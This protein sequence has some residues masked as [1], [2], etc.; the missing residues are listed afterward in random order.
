MLHS[1]LVTLSVG[2]AL[3]L[4][5]LPLTSLAARPEWQAAARTWPHAVDVKRA[6][7]PSQK[8]PL[9]Y[10]LRVCQSETL[11]I[12]GAC[13][14]PSV[15]SNENRAAIVFVQFFDD[16]RNKLTVP[17]LP[18]SR[19]FKCPYFHVPVGR[20]PARFSKELTAPANASH[21]EIR[22]S[23]FY[24]DKP[25]LLTDFKCTVRDPGKWT[26]R[27]QIVSVWFLLFVTAA[28]LAYF[29]LPRIQPYVLLAASCAFYAFF[30][31]MPFLFI[32]ASAASIWAGGLAI[33]RA[34]RGREWL[35]GAVVAFN[36]GILVLLKYIHP[37]TSVLVPLGI[38]FYSLQAISYAWDVK[39][40]AIPAERNP[41]KLALYLIF[42]PTVMQG[43][44]SRYGQIGAQLWS[45]HRYSWDRMQSGMELALWGFFKK[46]VIADRAAMLADAV[47]APGATM[48]GFP[49]LL[50]VICYSVQIYADF[51]GCVDICRGI[52]EVAGIEL[53]ENF[54]HPYFSTSVKD[55][56]HRWHISLSTWLRDYVYIP[57]GGNRKG[58]FRKHLN[59]LAT[60]G[61]SGVWHGVG[62]N[63]FAWGLLH[64]VYQVLDALTI[65]LRKRIVATLGIDDGSFSFRLGQRVWTFLLVSFAWI[66]FRA[67]TIADAWSVIR[68]MCVFNPWTWT[69][70]SCLKHGLDAMDFDVLVASLAVLVAVSFMQERFKVREWLARQLFWFRWLV[71]LCATFGILV[72]GIYGPGFNASQ[73]IYMQ[74]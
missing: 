17:E 46:M 50:G 19:S 60:F 18:F 70:G 52:C 3:A 6:K 68:R 16:E 48:E 38:S 13:E 37:W 10:N 30:G 14:S 67:P 29:C 12:E 8:A 40:G 71:Y 55:F 1:R 34:R 35:L 53:V 28:F 39:R 5:S 26:F 32:G 2:A 21:V 27:M 69:D 73:F 42:F 62:F 9:A 56:W 64:G 23:R 24:F 51:S 63:F 33:E 20:G 36:I 22:V 44:I 66:F 25:A 59:V 58:A 7:M 31:W 47:F 11:R 41:L 65:G 57:L 15:S 72:F 4:S 45:R 49:V 54:R 43:P 61:V 74:F